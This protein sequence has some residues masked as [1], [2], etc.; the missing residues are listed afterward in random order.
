MGFSFTLAPRWNAKMLLVV[1]YS[2]G[3]PLPSYQINHTQRLIISY[4]SPALAWLVSSQLFLN[5]SIY[6][7]PPGFY[8]SLFLYTFSFLL[9]P[10]LAGWLAP[11]VLLSLFLLLDLFLSR[12]FLL[13]ILPAWQP[14]LSFLLPRS[15]PFSSVLDHQVF[16]TGKE[17]QL[18]RVK[19]MQHKEKQH[20]LR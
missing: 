5:Y 13:F 14:Y 11:G 19:Q 2:L 10:S 1:F 4:K 18:H 8:L 7:L 3:G 15:W 6:L 16:E 12:F 9:V 20:F 17:S